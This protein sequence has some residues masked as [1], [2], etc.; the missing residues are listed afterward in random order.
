[1]SNN[2]FIG[3]MIGNTN[4]ITRQGKEWLK[5]AVMSTTASIIVDVWSSEDGDRFAVRVCGGRSSSYGDTIMIG[6]LSDLLAFAQDQS[7][8]N[9]QRVR[10]KY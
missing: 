2:K 6:F 4:P 3:E 10:P 9:H 1:M 7:A 8:K 5:T